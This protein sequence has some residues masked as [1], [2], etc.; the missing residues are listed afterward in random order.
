MS[1]QPDLEK[2]T[3]ASQV[4]GEDAEET[5]LLQEMLRHA[6]EYVTNFRWCPPIDQVY[7]GC[8]V[9]GILAVFLFHFRQRIH[10]TDEWLWIVEG[11]LP[12]AYIVL[13]RACD[14]PSAVEVYCQLMQ[15]WAKA[16]LEKRSVNVVF[17]VKAPPTPENAQNLMKRLNFI[18]QRLL[19]RWRANW[20]VK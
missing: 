11:D 6:T 12:A 15:D 1:P 16:V 8:G 13:D 10:G 9:G 19:P 2:L 5:A 20:P 3:P 17:P 14:P 18:R 7:F 4:T